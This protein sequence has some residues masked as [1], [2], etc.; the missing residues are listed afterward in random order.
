MTLRGKKNHIA[1]AAFLLI[2]GALLTVATF[3]D[4]EVSRIMTR[5]SLREGEFYTS[6]VFANFFE[7][8]GMLPKYLLRAFAAMSI[9]WFLGKSYLH[10]AL[11]VIL[12]LGGVGMAVYFLSA[13]FRDV[14]FYPMRHMIAEDV[15][16]AEA[17]IQAMTP[18][19][20]LL[21]YLL[22]AFF[23]GG[24][25]FCTRRVSQETWQKLAIFALAYFLMD[26]LSG[27]IVSYLKGYV[28]RIRFRSMNSVY[29]QAVGGFD[30]YTRWYEVTD[31]ADLFR[32]TILVH[33]TD[34]FR[35]FPSGH[36]GNAGCS[37]ALVMLI[38]C[39]DVKNKRAKAAL[40]ITP[41][42]WTGL[43]A[44]ARIV[45]GAHF[46]SDVLIGGTIPFLLMIFVREIYICRFENTKAMFPF[47]KKERAQ[48]EKG[49]NKS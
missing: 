43:T 5:F 47:F 24:A 1:V 12:F 13:G 20:Y 38:D 17:T 4:L 25:L 8:A 14:I 45:A 41:I 19:I 36:T 49:E 30:Q 37:Y 29:G 40:W 9:A 34:A 22:S 16:A 15:E 44:M 46:M 39:L 26:L 11:R 2:F 31:H 48:S 18:T 28:D 27:S 10:K 7:A 35:S 33:Y 21:S 3:Y 32:E 23:V 6:D 42:V